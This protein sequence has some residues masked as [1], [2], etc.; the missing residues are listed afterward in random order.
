MKN[1]FIY[2]VVTLMTFLFAL[3]FFNTTS[4]AGSQT[5]RDLHYDVTLNEDGSADVIETWKIEVYDTNTLFK[6]FELDDTKYGEITNV[7]V[8]EITSQGKENEFINTGEYAY[9]VKKG[10]FY[11]L[12]TS[13]NE[14][15]IAWGVGIEYREDKL[16]KISYKITNAI[17]NY[18]D[19]S[20]FYW[21]F[22]GENNGLSAGHITGTIKLPNKVNSKDDLKVWAHGPLYGNIEIVDNETV[23]FEVGYFPSETMLEVRVATTEKNM[24]LLNQ[25]KVMANKLDSILEEEGKWADDAN[26][27]RKRLERE[28]KM[29]EIA[30]YIMIGII[31]IAIVAVCVLFVFKIIKYAKQLKSVTRIKPETEYKYFRDF[32]DEFATPAEAAYLYYF[33]KSSLFTNNLSKVV[34]ATLLSL[35]LKKVISFVQDE[36]DKVYIVINREMD[37]T[38][39]D[40]EKSI[41]DLLIKIQ[42]SLKKK[43]KNEDAEVK[44]SMKDIEKYAK[45]HNTTFLSK[46]ECLE[47]LAKN[48]EIKKGNYSTDLIA[49]SQ[50]YQNLSVAYY[51]IAIFGILFTVFLLPL[52]L[53][54]LSL[55]CGVL[56]SKLSKR[57]R[58]LTQKGEN[59]KEQWKGLKRYMEDFSLLNEREVPELIMWEKFLVYATAFG[60]ADKVLKQLKIRYPQIV[61]ESYMMN[62]GYAYMYIMSRNSFDRA[63]LSGMQSAY[64]SGL[65]QRAMDSYSSGNYSSRKWSVVVAFR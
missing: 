19:C 54:I 15:E 48:S 57:F 12:N 40:D 43:N 16:Y 30:V 65:R 31:A 24:F 17:K 26:A 3:L 9:H 64:A 25:N 37:V 10:G 4:Y 7:R 41:Y 60:I 62:N 52:I 34:S 35:A 33:D 58:T 5:L 50:K 14:F 59:E 32:P 61:D 8:S 38:L 47:K 63:I 55:I 23:S 13:A 45:N 44:I 36:K 6:I 28:E 46:V 22:I 56:C 1:K 51:C 49:K 53:G 27:E 18:L 29:A 21:Q 11:A 2:F 39:E 20:E 42:E